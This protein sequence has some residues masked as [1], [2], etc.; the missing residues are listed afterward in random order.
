MLKE[1]KK[2]NIVGRQKKRERRIFPGVIVSAFL[3]SAVT[4]FLLL[5]IEK[6]LLSD[7][8]KALVWVA[9]EEM[10]RALEI[11][12]ENISKYFKPAE[13]DKRQMPE[14]CVGDVHGLAGS[15]TVLMIPKGTILSGSMFTNDEKYV[16]SL[17]EPVIVGC[18]AEDLYQ[19]ASGILRK[20]DMVNI[21][22]V[23]DELGEA[24]LLWSD[25]MIYQTFDNS[26][27]QI[28]AED[29]TTAAARINLL[30]EEWYTEQF[31]T[32]LHRGSLR[33]V[34]IWES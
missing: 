22:T 15:R 9:A 13:V 11:N 25:V 34:K 16:K 27:N 20:G 29:T 31:Y 1:T 33:M 12:N 18:K 4:F 10:P 5:N 14:N 28:A 24:Y 32:E 30:M 8:E 21:Y 26:G 17:T 3:A 6:N 19:V 7:Y 23:N 2:N